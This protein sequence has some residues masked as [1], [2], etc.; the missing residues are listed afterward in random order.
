MSELNPASG[1]EEATNTPN[2][3]K[4]EEERPDVKKVWRWINQLVSW[5]HPSSTIQAAPLCP[6]SSSLIC[7]WSDGLSFFLY[8][9]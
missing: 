9:K 2:Q 8:R 4:K 1:H 7:Y 6:C 3:V 5:I